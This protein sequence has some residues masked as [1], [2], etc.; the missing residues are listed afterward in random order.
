MSLIDVSF[1]TANEW[2][3][4]TLSEH[5]LCPLWTIVAFDVQSASILKV[6]ASGVS[7][8]S[9]LGDTQSGT[10]GHWKRTES[11]T[12]RHWKTHNLGQ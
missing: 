11:G 6:G 5:D 12:V 1:S 8:E 9:C 2:S 7:P 4:L 3:V 10:V